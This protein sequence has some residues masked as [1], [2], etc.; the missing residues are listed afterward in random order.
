MILPILAVEGDHRNFFDRSRFQASYVNAVTVRMRSGNI[1]G[2]YTTC[3][4]KHVYG[5]TGVECVGRKR[6]RTLDKSEARFGHDQ[7]EKSALTADRTVAFDRF[8]RRRRFNLEPHPAA[9][10]ATAVF[11]QVT[12]LRACA[13]TRPLPSAC[14][15]DRCGRRC[16][17]WR[18]DRK[19]SAP[20]GRWRVHL[21]TP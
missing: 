2:F 19:F 21:S 3:F 5:D 17:I 8:D 7:M 6:F 14:C 15:T 10:A 16:C 9:M 11:D 12:L 20:R 13:A 4:T 18:D 1:E